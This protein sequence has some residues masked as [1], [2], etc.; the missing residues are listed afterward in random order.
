MTSGSIRQPVTL[1]V[2]T[3]QFTLCDLMPGQMYTATLNGLSQGVTPEWILKGKNPVSVTGSV[4]R[5]RANAICQDIYLNH[6]STQPAQGYLSVWADR[7]PQPAKRNLST[8]LNVVH[9]TNPANTIAN[10]L[11]GNTCNEVS[12]VTFIGNSASLG[13]FSS[14]QT[15]IGISEGILLCTGDI[16]VLSGPNTKTNATGGFGAFSGQDIDL[17]AIA[18]GTQFDLTVIEFDVTPSETNMSFQFVF[19]SEEYCEYVNT[20]YNDVFGMFITGPG[21]NGK[22]NLARLPATNIPVSTNSVNHLINANHYVNNNDFD[23]QCQNLPPFAPNECQLDGW[24]KVLATNVTVIPCSTYHVKIAISDIGDGAWDSAVFL[25]SFS[26]ISTATVK[27]TPV[28]PNNQSAA[29]EGCQT[30]QIRFART[31]TNTTLPV[32]VT[33]TVSGTATPGIDYT[34][35]VSPVVIPAGQME[36]F[37]P[38]TILADQ[39]PEGN[40]TIVLNVAKSCDCD[41]NLDFIIGELPAFT[42][43]SPDVAS[44]GAATLQPQVSGGLPP[45]TYQ[46]STGSTKPQINAVF[47]AG[48]QEFTLTVADQCGHI[49]SD[50][51]SVTLFAPPPPT[52]AVQFCTGGSVEVFGQVYSDSKTFTYLKSG[53]NGQCDSIIDV[54]IVEVTEFTRQNDLILCPGQS[55]TLDG[56]DY[57]APDTVSLTQIGANGACDT[58]TSF[59]LKIA[60]GVTR[61]ETRSFCEGSSVTIDG[62]VYTGSGTVFDTIAGIGTTCDTLV[63][64]T[65][66]ATP[67]TKITDTHILCP[68]ETFTIGGQDYFAPNSV[69]ETLPGKN[70]QCD[71]VLTHLLTLKTSAPSSVSIVCPPNAT[72]FVEIGS[73][74]APVVFNAPTFS[75]NCP[76]PGMTSDQTG[77]LPSGSVF[78]MGITTNCFT[79]KDA[80]GNTASCCFQVTVKEKPA[81]DVKTSGCIKWETISAKEDAEGR[82]TFKIRVTN[83]CANQLV[84]ADFQLPK[85]LVAET[86]GQNDVYTA[87]SGREYLVTNPNFSPF[88]SIRFASLQTGIA[89]GASDIFQYTLQPQAKITYI[90]SLVRLSPSVY[91]AAHLTT[92]NCSSSQQSADRSAPEHEVQLFPNPT[93]GMIFA[94]IPV[95]DGETVPVRVLDSKGALVT[96]TTM[97][98]GAGPQPIQLPE[99]L[100]DGIY[101]LEVLLP[102]GKVEVLRFMV[103]RP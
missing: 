7:T 11:F 39:L 26:T 83:T 90:L 92:F 82:T 74:L 46:W 69:T 54:S 93:D 20:N 65:L 96:H 66:V 89:G 95:G 62:I 79:A 64:Y 16:S 2:G 27:A 78:P 47:P 38:V 41:P 49:Q 59:V 36:I 86:P 71:T 42:L 13:T 28:Y 12:N 17:A 21:I 80:C 100:T 5:F 94:D 84:S 24:T 73:P 15:N 52:L 1:S 85:G 32:P 68:G 18:A 56:N 43:A 76:C 55:V 25:R 31:G 22:Q 57:F 53:K 50:T 81:C 97:T 44:C 3:T 33:F 103:L 51:I 35:L 60:A 75:S 9:A 67:P 19:G 30:G 40:E 45:Y 34:P 29:F 6:P 23:F 91:Y 4:L 77:G 70:G 61:N 48:V 72:S 87:P 14:G 99:S 88:Y 8:G 102:D 63:T 98:A 37:I 58:I 10:T 101:L